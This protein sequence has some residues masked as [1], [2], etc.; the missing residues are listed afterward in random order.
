LVALPD[1]TVSGRLIFGKN[2]DRPAGECQ[3]LCSGPDAG[4]AAGGIEC[5]HIVVP[6]VPGA[7]RTLGCRPYW[8]WGYETGINETGVVGGN[9]AVFT[10]S[11]SQMTDQPYGLL[12]MEL[13]RF[14]LERGRTA[15]QA[16]EIVVGLL[17]RYGQWGPA[18]Q[19]RNDPDGCYENAFV[20]GDHKEVWR[21]ETSGRRWAARRQ[22]EGTLALSNQLTIRQEWTRASPDIEEYARTMGWTGADSA[23]LDFALS[24]SDHENYARQ[25]SHIR[26][27]RSRRLLSDAAPDIDVVTMMGFLRD[28]YEQTF[29]QGP[30]FSRYLPDFLTICMHDSPAHF[31]WGN[32]ATSVVAE[33]DPE[34]P[35]NTAY[36]VCYQPP[37]TSVYA[38]FFLNA[39]LPDAVTRVGATGR[40]GSPKTVVPDSF[41][42]DSLWWRLHRILNGVSQ[43]PEDRLPELRGEFDVLERDFRALAKGICHI[44]GNDRLEFVEE[45]QKKQ[46]NMI[47]NICSKLEKNWGLTSGNPEE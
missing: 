38:A 42:V 9:T 33:I 2:S 26:W 37:C 13:L 35:L 21:L 36:W 40:R 41:R 8:C 6:R 22:R 44:G 32:T 14:G 17:E 3:V 18:V 4:A 46:V 1:S 47:T 45:I 7:F 28:H 25:V 12:G 39:T 31:T 11:R 15:E 19:G 23:P 30:Q 29:I 34:N 5:A 24:Y 16:V 27:M 43:A 20:F 10:R